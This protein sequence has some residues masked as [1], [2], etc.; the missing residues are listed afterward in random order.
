MTDKDETSAS[1]SPEAAAPRRAETMASI[2]AAAGQLFSEH[3]TEAVSIRQIAARAGVSHTLVHK[4]FGTKEELVR[5]VI[6]ARDDQFAGLLSQV[7]SDREALR[8]TTR[9][10]LRSREQLRTTMYAA[11][12]GRSSEEVGGSWPAVGAFAERFMGERRGGAGEAAVDPRMVSAAMAALLLGWSVLQEMLL[13]AT[14]LEDLGEEEV[15]EALVELEIRMMGRTDDLG[16]DAGGAPSASNPG[17]P[18][19]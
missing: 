16:S 12:E 14:G 4:Y 15:V 8:E 18:E 17:F 10:V 7:S 3:G 13:E 19:R 6:G 2:V 11:L 1:A 9:A 5:V